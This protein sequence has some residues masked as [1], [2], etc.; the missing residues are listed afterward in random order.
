MKP[1]VIIVTASAVL[2][3]GILPAQSDESESTHNADPFHPKT[4]VV[5]TATR[6]ELEI[7]KSPMS[8]SIVTLKELEVRPMQTLDQHLALIEGLYIYR[9]QGPSAT[10]AQ[11]SLRGF[12]GSA[13]TSGQRRVLK[14]SELDRTARQ[15][16]AECRSRARTIFIAL[17]RQRAWWCDPYHDAS[18]RAQG[19]RSRG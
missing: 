3:G 10:D 7:D 19:T 13:R 16:G 18:C 8:T 11:A 5:V 14:R 15:R 17:W 12:N 4:T 9:T 6:S 2:F 1:I